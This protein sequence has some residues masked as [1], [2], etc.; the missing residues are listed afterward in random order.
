MTMLGEMLDKAERE[1]VDA[2]ILNEAS[3]R[4][5]VLLTDEQR[6]AA[7]DKTVETLK[8]GGYRTAALAVRRALG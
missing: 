8:A 4:Y 1:R 7:V 6:A 3:T 5:D 2:A